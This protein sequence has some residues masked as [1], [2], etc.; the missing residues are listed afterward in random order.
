MIGQRDR[1]ELLLVV[2]HLLKIK[3]KMLMTRMISY[4]H[5]NQP[6]WPL[7]LVDCLQMGRK[8]RQTEASKDP[9]DKGE[10]KLAN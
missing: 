10:E 3:T 7:V 2:E 6:G 4:P 1:E 5:H 9:V 8:S